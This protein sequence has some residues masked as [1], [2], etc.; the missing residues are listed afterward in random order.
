MT[1][2]KARAEVAAEVAAE[3]A[4]E[5]G[6]RHLSHNPQAQLGAVQAGL[7]LRCPYRRLSAKAPGAGPTARQLCGGA[8]GLRGGALGLLKPKGP[9]QSAGAL[10]MLE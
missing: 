4:A 9:T 5:A 6:I 8:L 10:R 1:T 3:A 2:A 7:P